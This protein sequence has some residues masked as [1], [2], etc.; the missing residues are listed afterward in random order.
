MHSDSRPNQTLTYSRISNE[1]VKL[2]SLF[3]ES[4][5][6]GYQQYRLS[7]LSNNYFSPFA[8]KIIKTIGNLIEEFENWAD[9]INSYLEIN[10]YAQSVIEQLSYLFAFVESGENYERSFYFHPSF[11]PGDNGGAGYGGGGSGYNSSNHIEENILVFS[12]LP[13]ELNLTSYQS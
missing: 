11:N 10:D 1:P 13:G 8:K 6:F 12:L 5:I 2:E 4:S 7:A 3:Y 9:T